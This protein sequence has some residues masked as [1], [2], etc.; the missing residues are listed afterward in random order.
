M[1]GLSSLF[2]RKPRKAPEAPMPVPPRGITELF[3]HDTPRSELDRASGL[4]R[5]KSTAA[6]QIDRRRAD[7]FTAIRMK[8]RN[9]FTPSQPVSD[10]RLFAGR[11]DTLAQMISSIEDQR[12]HLVL[13]GERGIG[14]TSLLHMLSEAAREARYIV[15]YLSCGS[16]SQFNDT[17]RTAAG[18]IPL[19]YHRGYGPTTEEAEAGSTLADLLPENF[20]PRQF[21]DLCVKLTGTRA[22]IILDEFDRAESSAFRRDL[23]EV[24]KSLSDRSVRVQVVIGGV[25]ADLGEL[26]EHIPSIRRNILAIRLPLMTED[27]IQ[28]MIA[29]GERSSG[30]VFDPVARELIATISCGWPYIASL[31]CHHSALHAIDSAR[32]TVIADDVLHALDEAI[33]EL[34][35]R[36]SRSIHGQIDRMIGEGM[37]KLLTLIGGASLGAGGPVTMEKIDARAGKPADAQAAKHMLEQLANDRVF[38]QRNED[39]YGVNYTF[40]EE[41]LPQYL[42]FLGTKANFESVRSRPPR[43]GAGPSAA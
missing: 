14:K 37:G 6:D 3:A 21:A 26:V 40:L 9:A 25:A 11:T 38:V 13:Y 7:R 22:L 28:A 5:F 20:T 23:A 34:A 32:G 4:P 42:W 2:K 1:A 8:L 43:V 18:S 39:V 17:F 33:E 29:T 27:E 15:V 16:A 35:A 19:L 12:L 10:R 36:I 31:V 30:M 24:L 41:G